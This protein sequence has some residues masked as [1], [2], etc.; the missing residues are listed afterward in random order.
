MKIN[1]YDRD[2]GWRHVCSEWLCM[3]TYFLLYLN[4]EHGKQ[5]SKTPV[6]I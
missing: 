6:E 1:I 4:C 3:D 5:K 2:S